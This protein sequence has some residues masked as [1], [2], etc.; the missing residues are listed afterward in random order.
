M[1]KTYTRK[2]IQEAIAYWERQL[3]ERLDMQPNYIKEVYRVIVLK[4]GRR[5][6]VYAR[7]FKRTG[8]GVIDFLPAD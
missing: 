7:I 3:H 1:K 5:T 6:D 4:D 2:Q 8:G